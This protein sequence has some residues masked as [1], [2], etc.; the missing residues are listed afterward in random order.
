MG[1]RLADPLGAARGIAARE[2]WAGR[3]ARRD[4]HASAGSG[5]AA[6]VEPWD[7]GA[8]DETTAPAGPD[9]LGM[10]LVNA[11]DSEAELEAT[12]ARRHEASAHFAK[13]HAERENAMRQAFSLLPKQGQPRTE[14]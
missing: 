6:A 2:A 9:L 14:D 3:I 7:P 8:G 4:P 1:D 13:F 12:R 10:H 11:V 5:L